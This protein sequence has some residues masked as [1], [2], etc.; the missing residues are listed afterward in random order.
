MNDSGYNEDRATT[1]KLAHRLR[2]SVEQIDRG[3]IA[4]GDKRC[5]EREQADGRDD[6]ESREGGFAAQQFTQQPAGRRALC[7]RG[8]DDADL[9]ERACRHRPTRI[10]GSIVL[11][12]MS[13]NRFVATTRTDTITAIASMRITSSDF[14]A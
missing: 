4:R 8:R 2:E 11:W 10:R 7:A 9:R 3:R 6:E 13:K 1:A 14:D 12:K 5:E